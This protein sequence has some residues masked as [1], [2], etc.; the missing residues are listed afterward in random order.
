[1]VKLQL[2]LDTVGLKEAFSLLGEVSS[3]ID[4]VEVGTPF[5]IRDGISAVTEIKTTLPSMEVLADLKIMDAGEFEQTSI[6]G[7]G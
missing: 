4:I 3:F 5:I 2:A 7:R 1:M 6:Q